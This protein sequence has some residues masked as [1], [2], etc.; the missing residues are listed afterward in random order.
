M[1][2][3][4]R[5]NDKS[6]RTLARKMGLQ[7]VRDP[8]SPSLG[9]EPVHLGSYGPYHAAPFL[10]HLVSTSPERWR[11]LGY[12]ETDRVSLVRHLKALH[13][14]TDKDVFLQAAR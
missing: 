3:M 8:S 10:S 11:E 4:T 2:E 12:T 9:D 13:C 6:L 7:N 5:W 14:R 1:T